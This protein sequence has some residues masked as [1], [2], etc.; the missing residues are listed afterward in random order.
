[1]DATLI[2]A[3]L[4]IT[5][6]IGLERIFKNCNFS[7]HNISRLAF[8]SLCCSGELNRVPSPTQSSTQSPTQSPTALTPTSL[9]GVIAENPLSRHPSED[10]PKRRLSL[11]D[12]QTILQNPMTTIIEKIEK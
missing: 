1:M 6:L 11:N 8:S 7:L 2:V 12:L 4:T 3:N 9:S 5:A 10:F